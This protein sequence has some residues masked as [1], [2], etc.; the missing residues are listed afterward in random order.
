MA[1]F[2]IEQLVIPDTLDG[3][4]G[5][6]FVA[7]IDARNASEVLGY[8]TPDVAY[9]A[10]EL[11]P[12][13]HDPH[14]PKALWGARVD[15][16]IVARATHEWQ[17]D[18]QD[19]AWLDL[20]VHPD[21]EGRGIGRALADAVEEHARS[22]GRKRLITYA[23]SPDGPGERLVP[24]TGAGAVPRENREV[25]FLLARRWRLEQIARASRF[26][27][28][29]DAADVAARRTDAES[30][31][32]G[33]YRIHTWTGPTPERWIADQAVLFTRMST[34][35]PTAGLESPEDPWDEDRVREFDALQADGPRDLLTA[36]AEHI[37]SGTLVAFTQ[38]GVPGDVSRPVT[39]E[40]T[41]VLREHRGH[42]L[43]MLLKVANLQYL[44]QTAPGH[45]CVLTWNA[46][47]NRAMLDV[48]EAVGFVPI[49]YEGAWRKDL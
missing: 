9:P 46:E 27:L 47:E 36:A 16:R 25:R 48:N 6:D 22:L 33:A 2:T 20:K 41:L 8:G 29:I 4:G 31:A 44:E 15:G 23:V 1:E 13:W 19:V 30:H 21:F 18:D 10:A 3:P 5:A 39:Q 45:P 26:P 49:A 28:P 40:D 34:E 12:F 14:E 11:L 43:G 38:L 7:S 32:G 42:R 17:P 35:E 24:P 37:D